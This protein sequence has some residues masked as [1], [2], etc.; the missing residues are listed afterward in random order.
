MNIEIIKST[1]ASIRFEVKANDI[2]EIIEEL[3]V[4]Y[5][6]QRVG[7]SSYSLGN[8]APLFVRSGNVAFMVDNPDDLQRACL[9]IARKI[10][11][12][13]NNPIVMKKE[14]RSR[15]RSD[16]ERALG[17]EMSLRRSTKRDL[18]V[19]YETY[20]GGERT[21]AVSIVDDLLSGDK[22]DNAKAIEAFKCLM[23]CK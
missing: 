23:I 13:I 4:T 8:A 7:S 3:H 11:T 10:D 18:E 5:G 6:S 9:E 22:K 1:L 20:E 12:S 15:W 16:I 19:V 14:T 21:I 2:D 17:Y